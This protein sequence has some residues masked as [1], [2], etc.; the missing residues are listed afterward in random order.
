MSAPPITVQVEYD[1]IKVRIGGTLHLYIVR[2][3][4]LAVHS[5][6]MERHGKYCIEYTTVDGDV[7]CDY[8]SVEKFNAILDGLDKVL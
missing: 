3:K 2:S 7:T 8:D 1:A 4:L 5:W 6:K